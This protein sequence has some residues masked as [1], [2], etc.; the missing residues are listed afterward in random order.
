MWGLL[1]WALGN[2]DMSNSVRE[3]DLCRTY[4]NIIELHGSTDLRHV[5]ALR[6]MLRSVSSLQGQ[7]KSLTRENLALHAA[8][9]G[10]SPDAAGTEFNYLEGSLT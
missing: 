2:T 3:M 10:H 1:Q 5:E 6:S 4:L 9:G 7:V 8:V